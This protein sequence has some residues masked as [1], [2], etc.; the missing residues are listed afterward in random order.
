MVMVVVL[1]MVMMHLL[2]AAAAGI[3][4]RANTNC[5]SQQKLFFV[6]PLYNPHPSPPPPH[7]V[8][9]S[10]EVFRIQPCELRRPFTLYFSSNLMHPLPQPLLPAVPSAFQLSG[11]DSK[12]LKQAIKSIFKCRTR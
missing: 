10:T 1:V 2:S 8:E 3:Y 9:K 4:D 6:S 7:H 11:K 5:L 12:S